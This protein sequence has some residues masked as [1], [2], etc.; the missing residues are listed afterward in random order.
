MKTIIDFIKVAIAMSIPF[1][2]SA[3]A[4]TIANLITGEQF[5]TI[6]YILLAIT[7]IVAKIKM[8]GGK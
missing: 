3:L 7:L 5:M 6:V 8:K 1:L 2:F 4:N